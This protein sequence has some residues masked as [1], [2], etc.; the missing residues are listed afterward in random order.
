[1]YLKSSL[2]TALVLI[3][4]MAGAAPSPNDFPTHN[5]KLFAKDKSGQPVIDL[6]FTVEVSVEELIGK[7]LIDGISSDIWRGSVIDRTKVLSDQDGSVIPG[8]SYR[9]N[10]FE[11][12]NPQVTFMLGPIVIKNYE[13]CRNPQRFSFKVL[14]APVC[15]DPT[16]TCP[17]GTLILQ[18]T[19][20]T[21]VGAW[22]NSV[23]VAG[24]TGI[25]NLPDHLD[26]EITGYIWDPKTN[27][28]TEAPIH[29]AIAKWVYQCDHPGEDN[30]DPAKCNEPNCKC[31]QPDCK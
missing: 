10:K 16:Q 15:T 4:L 3:S 19:P 29:E 21:V 12:R 17:G 20:K 14:N 24:V 23:A 26:L 7:W 11:R 1:M 22:E 25:W 28:Q 9:K 27:T 31:D 30:D 5:I 18:P 13:R 2:I 6:K 8:S